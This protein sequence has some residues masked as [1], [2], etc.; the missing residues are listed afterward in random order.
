MNT[1]HGTCRTEHGSGGGSEQSLGERVTAKYHGLDQGGQGKGPVRG[2]INGAELEGS[3]KRRALSKPALRG[4]VA[5]GA[6]EAGKRHAP[7]AARSQNTGESAE[8]GQTGS[9]GEGWR[10]P[11]RRP[12]PVMPH[13]EPRIHHTGTE[14]GG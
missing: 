9:K 11:Q 6:A 8:A 2:A 12:A 3:G 10:Q 5:A 13:E 7:Q 1:R 4:G 14:R